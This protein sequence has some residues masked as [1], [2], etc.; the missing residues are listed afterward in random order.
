M[1][2]PFITENTGNVTRADLVQ[3]L[4]GELK[5]LTLGECKALVDGFFDVIADRLVEGQAVRINGL[6]TFEVRQKRERPG[7]NL[8]T[9]GRSDDPRPPRRPLS[10]RADAARPRDG[11]HARRQR[12]TE[13]GRKKG[14]A[15]IFFREPLTFFGNLLY[16]ISSRGVAQP[17]SALAWGARGREFESRRPD[18][19]QEKEMTSVVS[20]FI[21]CRPQDSPLRRRTRSRPV[22]AFLPFGVQGAP[23]NARKK[24]LRGKIFT[25]KNPRVRKPGA[26]FH[27]PSLQ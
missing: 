26:V 4:A 24:C 22:N 6:G 11:H 17:G 5:D 18:Q 7:R 16:F 3:H 13:T 1:T 20:F 14:R 27:Q 19:I 12:L 2:S 25:L 9:G 15:K 8:H 10:S 23:Q 21:A